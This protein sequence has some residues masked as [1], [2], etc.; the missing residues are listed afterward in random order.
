MVAG[1]FGLIGSTALLG[2]A[3]VAYLFAKIRALPSKMPKRL[4]LLPL[5]RTAL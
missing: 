4:K 3:I 2:L 5:L 1:H